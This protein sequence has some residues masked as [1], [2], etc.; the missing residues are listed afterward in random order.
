MNTA[1]KELLTYVSGLGP[2]L[3]ENIVRYRDENGPFISRAALKKVPRLGEKAFEQAAGFLRIANAKNVL[4][5][6]AVHPERYELVKRMALDAGTSLEDLVKSAEKR[7]KVDL[8]KY[9]DNEVGMPTLK[10]ILTELEKPGRDPR[11]QFE[12]FSFQ[13]G[14]NEISD[15]KIG[16]KLPGIVTNLTKFGAFVDVGVH[17][18]GLVHVSQLSDSFVS[19]PTE[20]VKLQDK[21]QVIITEVD[22]AR[23]RISLSMKSDPFGKPKQKGPAKKKDNQ[24]KRS[25]EPEGDLQAKLAMLKGKFR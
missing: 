6:S 5:K 9:V 19:D 1:S 25:Q 3:A 14:V 20:V 12:V 24:P 21:V 7:A 22:A 13:E 2:Q 10:D 11:E 15:L 4:D 8:K 17:Q 16:M 23:K 18:D